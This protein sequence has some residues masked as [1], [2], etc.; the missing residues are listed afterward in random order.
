MHGEKNINFSLILI[1]NAM[2]TSQGSSSAVSI[3][4]LFQ[5]RNIHILSQTV[6]D[7]NVASGLV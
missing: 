5:R 3:T 6:V 1:A 2:H 7:I 4:P